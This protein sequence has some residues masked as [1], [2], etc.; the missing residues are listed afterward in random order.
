MYCPNGI[1]N[2]PVSDVAT[3]NLHAALHVFHLALRRPFCPWV[4][5]HEAGGAR[6]CGWAWSLDALVPPPDGGGFAAAEVRQ[7]RLSPP[8]SRARPRFMYSSPRA[9]LPTC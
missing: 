2:A 1:E 3:Q 9:K 4:K 8:C 5:W 7:W 6:R